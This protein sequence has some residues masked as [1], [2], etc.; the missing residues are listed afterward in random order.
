MLANKSRLMLPVLA[1][2]A[3]SASAYALYQQPK[4]PEQPASAKKPVAAP[5]ADLGLDKSQSVSVESEDF[6]AT[7]S[8][9]NTGLTHVVMKDPRYVDDSGK[10]I[11]LVTTDKPLYLP[12]RLAVK[13][14]D[15]PLD[16]D[17][18]VIDSTP[19]SARFRMRAGDLT[20][21]RKLE[22]GSGPFQ[23]WS[24]LRIENTGSAAKKVEVSV[25][26]HH[27]ARRAD[28]E[29]GILA[30]RSPLTTAGLCV[31]DGD[32]ERKDREDIVEDAPAFKGKVAFG[33]LDTVYF[34]QAIAAEG[35]PFAG[36]RLKGSDR[37]GSADK[38][39]GSLLSVTL[40]HPATDVPPGG[41]VTL[42][43]LA[44]FGPKLPKYLQRAGHELP[45]AS[46]QGGMPGIDSIARG[47]VG[48]LSFIHDRAVHNW[49][50][51][52]ILLTLLVKTVLYPL[53]ARSF[54]SMAS[55]RKLKP[56]IDQINEKYADD[57][58]KKGAA[59]MELYRTHKINPL[60]G[61]LPQLLQLPIWWALYMSLSSNVELF[62]R[63]FFAFWQDLAAPD[64]YYV[65]PLALGALMWVQQ[66]ITPSTMDPAQA[67]MML[68][69]MPTMI[70]AFMLFLP[71]GLCLYMLTNSLLSIAQQR[72]IEYRLTGKNNGVAPSATGGASGSPS[73]AGGD[74]ASPGRT[75]RGRA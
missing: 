61:C 42:R 30:G 50:L 16:K 73:G 31:H 60:G 37:G 24:T 19:T 28:E 65:L 47:L 15:L 54:A 26:G 33:S 44:F 40:D 46:Y 12:L 13:G 39:D 27:Y 36:C 43:T 22:V 3:L 35:K 62:R 14:V 18:E 11:E 51:A 45:M 71:A 5:A 55:M 34:A 69:V 64:P 8:A 52:I 57:R 38:P 17:W 66:K 6:R 49:G 63:P 29:G 4:A 48:M 53:T 72:F 20:F 59:M 74:S 68:Y 21:V 10:P 41:Q 7:I 56:A 32:P 75:G 1:L 67:K 2:C 23:I 9:R 25:E 58:E 70:T